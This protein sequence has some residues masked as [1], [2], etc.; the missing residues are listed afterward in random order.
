MNLVLRKNLEYSI[1]RCIGL[2]LCS[3]NI[4][5]AVGN[6]FLDLLYCCLLYILGNFGI[7]LSILKVLFPII[8]Y[9][10]YV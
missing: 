7:K 2:S 8:R 3:F 9:M 5:M 1:S 6:L 10:D 4:S